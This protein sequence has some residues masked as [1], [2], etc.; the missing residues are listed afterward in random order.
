MPAPRRRWH[1]ITGQ[2]PREN[3]RARSDVG[4]DLPTGLAVHSVRVRPIEMGEEPVHPGTAVQQVG[5]VIVV[6]RRGVE[7]VR[8]VYTAAEAAVALPDARGVTHVGLA[9]L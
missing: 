1:A 4:D 3:R 8:A 2:V 5:R 6:D 7:S 9:S